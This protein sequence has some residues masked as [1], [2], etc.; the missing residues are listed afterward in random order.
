M[1]QDHEHRDS[2]QARTPTT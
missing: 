1:G 2:E